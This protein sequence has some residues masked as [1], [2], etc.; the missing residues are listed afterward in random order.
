MAEGA[1]C[2]N[3]INSGLEQT[4]QEVNEQATY[5][6]EY[7]YRNEISSIVVHIVPYLFWWNI[8]CLDGWFVDRRGNKEG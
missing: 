7:G 4:T 3:V 5:L 6:Q 1:E 8:R 2:W